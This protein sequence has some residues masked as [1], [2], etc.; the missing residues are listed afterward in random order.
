L[1]EERKGD[2][3]QHQTAEHLRSQYI[4]RP[5][6][7]GLGP[8][9]SKLERAKGGGKGGVNNQKQRPPRRVVEN[10][11]LDEERDE[12]LGCGLGAKDLR[13]KKK[14][15]AGLIRGEEIPSSAQVTREVKKENCFH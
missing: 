13:L 14:E 11:R 2:Q 5:K 6:K 3:V 12:K 1:G 15:P 8:L 9:N 4:S 7:S 10:E